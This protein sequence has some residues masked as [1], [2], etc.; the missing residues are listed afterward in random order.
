MNKTKKNSGC[1]CNFSNEGGKRKTR[2]N[3]L[4]FLQGIAVFGKN[5][6]GVEGII[7]V[8]EPADRDWLITTP[9]QDYSAL[10]KYLNPTQEF[11]LP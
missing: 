8:K 5:K 11:F 9:P 3:T 1:A 4:A 6:N 10:K 2:R 7:R